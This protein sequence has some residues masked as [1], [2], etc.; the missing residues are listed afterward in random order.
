MSNTLSVSSPK[1][2]S[3]TPNPK[4]NRGEH[5][6][7][8]ATPTETRSSYLTAEP[9]GPAVGIHVGSLGVPAA[10]VDASRALRGIRSTRLSP[11][12]RFHLFA[13]GGYRQAV[14][15]VRHLVH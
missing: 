6:R 11:T 4:S 9:G 3:K 14:I 13:E 12:E 5:S 10:L 15:S 8:F 7:D 2:A 1:G